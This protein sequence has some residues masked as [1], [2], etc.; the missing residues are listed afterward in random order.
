MLFPKYP[1]LTGLKKNSQDYNGAGRIPKPGA[2][3]SRIIKKT[4]IAF[5]VVE[6]P[7]PLQAQ[8]LRFLL[9]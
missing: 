5:T 8:V 7:V 3:A 2:Q 4:V 6:I 9:H 1:T